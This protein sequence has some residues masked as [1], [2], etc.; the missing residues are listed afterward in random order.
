MSN[1]LS[2][3]QRTILALQHR[4]V[5]LEQM[6][7]EYNAF[8]NYVI[9]KYGISH[10]EDGS[11]FVIESSVIKELK[12]CPIKSEIVDNGARMVLTRVD[13]SGNDKSVIVLPA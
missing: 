2:A 4:I 11:S 7:L 1:H 6:Q 9:W 3:S 8:L 10:D 12:M 5:E 13:N